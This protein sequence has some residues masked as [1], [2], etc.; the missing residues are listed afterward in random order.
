MDFG[1]HKHH[2]FDRAYQ[3]AA[4]VRWVWGEETADSRPN[5]RAFKRY[6]RDRE[7]HSPQHLPPGAALPGG[8]HAGFMAVTD[9][10]VAPLMAPSSEKIYTVLD[11]GCNSS[12][13]GSEWA[14]RAIEVL[15]KHGR[16]LDW[17]CE[18]SA[19]QYRGIGSA[20]VFT[21]GVR[22]IPLGLQLADG[23]NVNG[24]IDSAELDG[25]SAPLLL[26]VQAQR[27][28]GMVVDL[29]TNAVFSKLSTASWSL[30]CS[31]TA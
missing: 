7:P 21:R 13:H 9:R 25:S 3:D 20:S 27:Q 31:P 4:Y 14:E 22:R 30:R 16:T 1:K 6:I 29:D 24:T 19:P 26:S 17:A 11:N 10:K 5:F 2:T 23:S 15:A 8:G 18:Q 12:C 28:L